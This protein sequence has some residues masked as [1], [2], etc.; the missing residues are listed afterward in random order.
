MPGWVKSNK[1]V[2]MFAFIVLVFAF[3]TSLVIK[4]YY[5]ISS[6][7]GV[8]TFKTPEITFESGKT[9]NLSSYEIQRNPGWMLTDH[10]ISRHKDSP[11]VF[12]V[13]GPSRREGN[14]IF[15]YTNEAEVNKLEQD[16]RDRLLSFIVVSFLMDKYNLTEEEANE[17]THKMYEEDAF[18]KW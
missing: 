18:L 7:P 4:G 14:E 1:L 9:I 12:C 10:C 15:V 5:R 6:D 11:K 13:Q 16:E 2:V 8:I 17:I 3:A